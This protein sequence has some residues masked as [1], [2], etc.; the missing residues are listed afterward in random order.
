MGEETL[1]LD[2]VNEEGQNH[3]GQRKNN[4]ELWG[5]VGVSMGLECIW[6][7]RGLWG[8]GC[9]SQRACVQPSQYLSALGV[10]L[11]DSQQAMVSNEPGAWGLERNKSGVLPASG[12][13]QSD[14]GH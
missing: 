6:G 12:E 2:C 13:L 4:F 14:G 1:E 7:T 8:R 11:P 10:G 9:R 5:R 3:S